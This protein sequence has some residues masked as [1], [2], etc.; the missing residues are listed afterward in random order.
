MLPRLGQSGPGSNDNEVMVCIPKRK[1]GKRMK[2]VGKNP[3]NLGQKNYMIDIYALSY[4]N[5]TKQKKKKQKT[6]NK[7]KTK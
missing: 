6:K 4:K 5:K 2:R 1:V 7:T 3:Q